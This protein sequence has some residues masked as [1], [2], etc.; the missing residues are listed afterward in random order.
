[1]NIGAGP[2][3]TLNNMNS[4]PAGDLNAAGAGRVSEED[5]DGEDDEDSDNSD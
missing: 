1:M 4:I 3:P 5:F 2:G